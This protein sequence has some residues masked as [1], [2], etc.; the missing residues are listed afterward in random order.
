MQCTYQIDIDLGVAQSSVSTVAPD[1][2]IC[3][4]N[5][6]YLVD[7]FDAPVLIHIAFG[8]DE[9]HIAVIILIEDLIEPENLLNENNVCVIASYHS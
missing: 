9:A 7:Q 5:G 8:I 1:N 3:G 4:F 6:C 2:A